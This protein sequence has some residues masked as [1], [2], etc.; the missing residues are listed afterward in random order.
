MQD[1]FTVDAGDWAVIL[2]WVTGGSEKWAA[3]IQAAPS[4]A[5]PRL[6][7]VIC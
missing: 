6:I 7:S 4:L 1:D 2:D 3:K 5:Y